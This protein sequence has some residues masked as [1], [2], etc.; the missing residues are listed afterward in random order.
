[1][2]PKSKNFFH[3]EFLCC[4]PQIHVFLSFVFAAEFYMTLHLNEK[5]VHSYFTFLKEES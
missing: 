3:A 5:V 2:N 4:P 1:M